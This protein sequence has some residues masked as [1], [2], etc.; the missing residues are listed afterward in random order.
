MISPFLLPSNFK[1]YGPINLSLIWIPP[2]SNVL[3]WTS[4]NLL[5]VFFYCIRHSPDYQQPYMSTHLSH[6]MYLASSFQWSAVRLI[7]GEFSRPLN[8]EPLPGQLISH[9]SKQGF[10][11]HP[12]SYPMTL[13]LTLNPDVLQDE[14]RKNWSTKI[15]TFL[16]A[17]FPALMTT[18]ITA[19]FANHPIT[20]P[21]FV[22]N[23]TA[24][25]PALGGIP[26]LD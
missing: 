19:L 3:N 16:P 17:V 15:G 5:A 13:L 1:N 12:K 22:P 20:K 10:S 26:A 23:T 21:L 24:L 14:G 25:P 7:T 4:P 18:H 8:K 6:F 9:A 2:T 11:F